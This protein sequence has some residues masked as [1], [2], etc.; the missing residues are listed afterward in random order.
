MAK[1]K[2]QSFFVIICNHDMRTFNVVGP[3]LDD[4][5]W[6]ERVSAVR[7]Q[8]RQVNCSTANGASIGEIARSYAAAHGYVLSE[9]SVI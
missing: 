9:E 6:I 3:M 5:L 8:G 7:K 1:Q 2:R 4:T